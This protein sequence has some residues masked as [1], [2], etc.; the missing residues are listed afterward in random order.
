MFGVCSMRTSARVGLWKMFLQLQETLFSSYI[1]RRSTRLCCVCSLC[2]GCSTSDCEVKS[3]RKRRRV[4][5]TK[6]LRAHARARGGRARARGGRAPL[7]SCTRFTEPAS[8]SNNTRLILDVD[9]P[10]IFT[11]PVS[12][13]SSSSDSL[14]TV[15]VL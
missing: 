1:R 7:C 12:S 11:A 9:Y 4:K 3:C 5:K 15:T 13:F 2:S 6:S 14:I 8:L 10:A